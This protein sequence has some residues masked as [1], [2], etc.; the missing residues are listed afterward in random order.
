MEDEG[1][2]MRDTKS[3][4]LN[5]RKRSFD[6]RRP[7]ARRLPSEDCLRSPPI[8]SSN[9]SRRH[10]PGG[11]PNACRKVISED[12]TDRIVEAYKQIESSSIAISQ[13]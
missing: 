5:C 4:R 6:R 2:R 1:W 11:E 10:D 3:A 12:P 8:N 13:A 9:V 7:P